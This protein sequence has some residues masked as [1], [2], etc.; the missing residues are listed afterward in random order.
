MCKAA[1]CIAS[2]PTDKTLN[3]FTACCGQ[4]V[5]RGDRLPKELKQATCFLPEPVGC[6]IRRAT[7][8]M[9]DGITTVNNNP[10]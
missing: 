6:L 1:R 4:T 10:V 9:K 3:H 8:E 5:F 2:V 7:V